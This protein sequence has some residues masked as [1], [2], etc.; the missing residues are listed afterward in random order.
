VKVTGSTAS[1]T[2]TGADDGPGTIALVRSGGK[3]LLDDDTLG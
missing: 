2:V 1:A 3:W